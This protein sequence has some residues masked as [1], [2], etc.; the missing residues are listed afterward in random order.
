MKS[1]LRG[2]KSIMATVFMLTSLLSSPSY[3]ASSSSLQ[4]NETSNGKSYAVNVGAKVSVTLGSMFWSAAH[5]KAGGA[6]IW[7][8]AP[9]A[10][11]ILPGAG[12]PPR[13]RMPGMGCGTQTWNLIA[14]KKGIYTFSAIRSSCGEAKRCTGNQGIFEQRLRAG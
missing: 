13:C 9:V 3:A 5:P 10:Q 8:G 7:V 11:P 14:K 1:G 12:A 6:F 2:K 4:L